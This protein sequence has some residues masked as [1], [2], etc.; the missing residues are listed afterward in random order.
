MS[1]TKAG[2]QKSIK[3]LRDYCFEWDLEINLQKT[4]VMVF[5][6]SGKLSTDEFTY[7]EV[8]I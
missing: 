4:K 3:K 7:M 2:L 6:K 8:I 1:K 5:N